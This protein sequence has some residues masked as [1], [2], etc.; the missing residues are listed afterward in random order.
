MT[1]Y[2]LNTM[3]ILLTLMLYR[4]SVCGYI[5]NSRESGRRAIAVLLPVGIVL[6]CAAVI[7][8]LTFF[9]ACYVCGAAVVCFFLRNQLTEIFRVEYAKEH[10]RLHAAKAAGVICLTLWYGLALFYRTDIGEP[11]GVSNYLYHKYNE[12]FYCLGEKYEGRQYKF[13][14]KNGDRKADGFNVVRK[15]SLSVGSR[16]FAS[17]N[18]YGIIIRDDYQAFCKEIIKK[19][20]GNADDVDVTVKFNYS[21]LSNAAYMSDVFDRSTSLDEF[22]KYQKEHTS[23]HNSAD[24]TVKLPTSYFGL[25]ETQDMILGLTNELAEKTNCVSIDFIYD[26]AKDYKLGYT[27]AYISYYGEV[28]IDNREN[29]D[30]V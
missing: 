10:G 30:N 23:G 28:E 21:G 29:L 12:E 25:T 18:Y 19:Y 4:R 5:K 26:K 27:Y 11:I 20:Y 14:P 16:L 3:V 6:A 24:I 8:L 22:F 2:I 17:D 15:K 7:I 9:E 13:C 1:K